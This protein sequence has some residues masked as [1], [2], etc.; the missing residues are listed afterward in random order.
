MVSIPSS[1][2]ATGKRRKKYFAKKTAAEKFAA[3]LRASFAAGHRRAAIPHSLAL[4]A[5]EAERILEGSGI[6]IA[7]AARMAVNRMGAPADRETFADRYARAQLGNEGRWSDRYARD[8]ANLWR[9]VPRWFL[10]LP[11]GSI[12]RETMERALTEGGAKARSTLDARCRY[13]SAVVGF[14]DR[15]HKSAEVAIMSARQCAQMLRACESPA[16]RRAVALLVWAGIRPSA[17]DGEISRLDWSA[18]GA[19]EIYVSRE[20]SK[21][22]S[23]RYIPIHP[24]L[25]RLLRGHPAQGPVAPANWRRVYRRLRGAVE[26]IAGAQDVTRHTYA[27]HHLAAFGEAATR[28]AMGHA[29]QSRTLF[30]HYRA[31]VNEAAGVRFFGGVKKR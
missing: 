15:H 27:S 20:V 4:Q 29:D 12:D 6:S 5:A 25:R 13:L 24:R 21:T 3:S 19:A 28:A 14:R 2:M 11:C 8:M 10:S 7:E 22:G 9:W 18:V 1:M 31:A 16:E 17:E 23:D 30:R 26:G